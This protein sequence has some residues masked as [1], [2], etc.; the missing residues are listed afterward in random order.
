MGRGVALSSQVVLGETGWGKFEWALPWQ[1]SSYVATRSKI[2][3]AP[4]P[5]WVIEGIPLLE[6]K[7]T[8]EP[9]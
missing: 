8:R 5:R 6:E 2:R 1:A 4:A 7:R 3:G 9:E